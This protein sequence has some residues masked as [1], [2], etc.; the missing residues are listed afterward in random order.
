MKKESYT[1]NVRAVP[2]EVWLRAKHNA[3]ESCLPFR[4]Y[5]IRLLQQSEPFPTPPTKP[6]PRWEDLMSKPES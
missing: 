3:L 5:I 6:E 4:D 2:H 1:L